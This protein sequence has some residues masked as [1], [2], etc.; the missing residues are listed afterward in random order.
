M[1][2][3]RIRT[4]RLLLRRFAR[5][6]VESIHEAV[7]AS[8]PQLAEFLP[9]AHASYNRTDA[10][11]Y[12]RDSM[13]AWK[14][15][16]AFDYAI[17]RLE[18]PGRHIGNISIWHISRLGRTAEVGYWIRTDETGTGIATEA[19]AA[20]VDTGFA[21]LGLHKITLRIARGNKASERI[22][23]KLG[24]VK[25]G[26]LRDELRIRGVWVDHTLYSLLEHERVRRALQ[27]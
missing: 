22:A 13:A 16:R 19:T 6:D 12:V 25:E 9:W 23:D 21:E 2:P 8:L 4:D 5:R 26:V 24:F 10:A 7:D 3:D 11:A 14:E 18:E 20:L 27:S 17:R 1:V 15:G